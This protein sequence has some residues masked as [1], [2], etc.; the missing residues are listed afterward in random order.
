MLVCRI[1]EHLDIA[2]RARSRLGVGPDVPAADI[3]RPKYMRTE[4]FQRTIGVIIRNEHKA[5]ELLI[6]G[7]ERVKMPGILDSEVPPASNLKRG[8]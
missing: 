2:N 5:M 6:D 3:K 1:T 7:L 4:R 8:G